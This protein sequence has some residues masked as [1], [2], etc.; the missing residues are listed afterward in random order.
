MV[1]KRARIGR[2]FAQAIVFLLLCGVVGG[3]LPE[4][5]TLTDNTTN[6][7]TIRTTTNSVISP[8]LRS[9]SRRA[10]VADVASPK[11]TADDILPVHFHRFERATSS[12]DAPNLGT[13]LRT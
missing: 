1:S 5:L 13:V 8:L 6:D 3:E 9:G 10:G 2:V 11:I 7:F 12:R 4:L